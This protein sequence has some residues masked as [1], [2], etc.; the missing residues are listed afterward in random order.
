[1]TNLGVF[2]Q[3][4]VVVSDTSQAAHQTGAYPGFCNMKQLGVFLL[5]L[6]GNDNPSQGYPPP[7]P[8]IKFTGTIQT[9][10]SRDIL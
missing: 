6:D 9:P 7:P 2:L 1:M 3:G 10:W 5:P 8:S 4:C